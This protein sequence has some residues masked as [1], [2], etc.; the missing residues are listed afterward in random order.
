MKDEIC[1]CGEGALCR[2]VCVQCRILYAHVREQNHQN[3]SICVS[4][5]EL[6]QPRHIVLVNTARK[7]LKLVIKQISSCWE[8]S[9]A[10]KQTNILLDKRLKRLPR[11]EYRRIR[12]RER[13]YLRVILILR[14]VHLVEVL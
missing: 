9:I 13:T 11:H 12:R 3:Q 8:L 4:A 2:F 10:A 5:I 1:S 14:T 6:N 7:Y